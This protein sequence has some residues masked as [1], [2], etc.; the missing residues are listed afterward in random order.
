MSTELTKRVSMSIQELAN[1][2]DTYLENVAGGKRQAF[3]LIVADSDGI[4]H[5]VYNTTRE[6]ARTLLEGQIEFW[7][8]EKAEI[9]AHYNPDLKT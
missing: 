8:T 6:N 9:P 5:D 3:V 7:K 4:A 1:G 2:I